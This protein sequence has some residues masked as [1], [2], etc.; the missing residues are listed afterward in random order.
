VVAEATPEA[1]EAEVE[2]PATAEL[3]EPPPAEVEVAEGP[4]ETPGDANKA[5]EEEAG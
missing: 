2:E 4:D 5:D 1:P 3:D